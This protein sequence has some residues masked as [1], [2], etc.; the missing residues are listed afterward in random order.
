MHEQIVTCSKTGSVTFYDVQPGNY[1]DLLLY[2]RDYKRLTNHN[3][4]SWVDNY[5]NKLTKSHSN[6]SKAAHTLHA[7]DSVAAEVTE[8]CR[9]SKS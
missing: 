7:Q 5:C 4:S 2:T 6:L 1:M 9:G 8:I 3:G